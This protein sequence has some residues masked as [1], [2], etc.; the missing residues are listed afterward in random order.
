MTEF[1][2]YDPADAPALLALFRDTVRRVNRR[3]YSPDQIEAW[4]AEAID[5]AE[6]AARFAGRHVV[7]AAEE[8]RLVGF[9]ELEPDGHIDRMFVAADA[10]GRRI[11]S[12]LLAL[13]VAEARSR[14]RAVPRLFVEASIT[15]RPFFARHE[16]VTL[17]EQ[18]VVLRGVEFLNYRME[19]HLQSANR[20]TEAGRR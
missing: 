17:A 14:S 3:D 1:R 20:G 5:P 12:A 4:A 18:T 15:A 8:C 10:V 2:P 6:W 9:I 19:R 13:V 11:G 7:V 16:F